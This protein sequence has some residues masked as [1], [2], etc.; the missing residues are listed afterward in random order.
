MHRRAATA[1]RRGRALASIDR[2]R[3]VVAGVAHRRHAHRQL[4]QAREVVADVHVAVPQAG[5]QR[6]AA[7]VDDLRARRHLRL[8]RRA[9]RG[10]QAL[11]HDHRLIGE[12][13]LCV[14]VEHLHVG[15]RDRARRASSP[16][17]WPAPAPAPPARWSALRS[18]AGARRRR[19]PAASSGR[20]KSRRTCCW[21]PPRSEPASWLMPVTA[22]AVTSFFGAPSPTVR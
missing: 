8:V 21:R 3:V 17:T 13:H 7:A 12:E 18:D 5:Q 6:L 14:G 9:H 20:T 16:A 1:A 2:L 15:E 10:D 19:L 22:Q 4:L 11:V